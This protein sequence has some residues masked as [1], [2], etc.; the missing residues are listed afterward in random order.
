MNDKELSIYVGQ[1]IKDFRLSR[2][3]TQK[4]LAERI[5]MGDTTIVNYEKGIRTPKKNTL[6]KISEVLK[7]SIDD[8]FP[9]IT[10]TAPNSL[11]EQISDK[12][13][14]LTEPNQKSVLRYSS[15]LL[16]KQN[17]V[18]YSKNTVNEPQSIYFT[19]NYYD[20]PASAGTGQYLND[21]KVETIELPIEV[22]ADFVVPIY[23][24]SMEPEHHSGDYVFVKLSVDLS[25]GDIGVFAYN[26]EA[27]IKQLRITDQGAYLHSLNPDYDDIPITADTDFRT[28]GEVVDVYRER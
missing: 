19:Y 24:D 8:F 15:E 6:F 11:I 27:Y 16:D 23:G 7:T 1:K 14:Q 5:G 20:Q 18:T 4:E 25:D 17:T 3:M 26:G 21:V 28:I 10:P 9:P 22:D 13:V 2:N 12:V